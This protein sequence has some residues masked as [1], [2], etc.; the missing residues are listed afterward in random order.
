MGRP[1][2]WVTEVTGRPSM[3]SPGCPPAR[4]GIERQFWGRV[5]L[6]LSSEDAA[7]ACG[8]SAPVGAR[9]FRQ[10]GGVPGLDLHEPSGRYLSFVEREEIALLR[11]QLLGVR[12]IARRLG[13]SPSTVSREVR[14]NAA[15][16]GGQLD[17]RASVAQ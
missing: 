14:R 7:F 11:A 3:R 9:W 16:Q 5:A 15:T 10:G 8:V 1:Q 4:R 6:G 17:Y 12:E 13:R 2:G